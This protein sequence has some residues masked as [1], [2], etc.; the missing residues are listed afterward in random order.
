MSKIDEALVFL[1]DGEWHG[2]SE[3]SHVLQIE[4]QKLEKILELLK[5]FNFIQTKEL[6]VRITF[7]VKKFI[8][9][10]NKDLERKGIYHK[11]NSTVSL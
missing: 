10:T 4:C 8:D 6:K 5:E 11:I 7:D 1:L 9:S 2:L 3:M